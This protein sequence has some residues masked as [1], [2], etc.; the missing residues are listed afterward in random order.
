MTTTARWWHKA[1]SLVCCK[2]GTQADNTPSFQYRIPP[3]QEKQGKLAALTFTGE[4]IFISCTRF[5]NRATFLRLSLVLLCLYFAFIFGFAIIIN[6][7]IVLYDNRGETCVPSYD[8]VRGA[9][10]PNFLRSFDLSWTTLSTVGYGVISTT[11]DDA[12][13]GLRYLLALEGYNG[14]V[15]SGFCGGMFFLKISRLHSRAFATFSSCMCLE[16]G[17]D[18]VPDRDLLRVQSMHPTRFSTTAAGSH[19]RHDDGM[20]HS[21]SN[22]FP[23]LTFRLLNSQGVTGGEIVNASMKCMMISVDDSSNDGQ[24]TDTSDRVSIETEQVNSGVNTSQESNNIKKIMMQVFFSLKELRLQG[25]LH[26]VESTL[27]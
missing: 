4:R 15:F 27:E 11:A 25:H 18:V 5:L 10:R 20:V 8:Y 6:V 23:V 21:N 16:F 24:S 26:F 14:I 13:L 7:V 22:S 9:S 2:A 1:T 17:R 3:R 19:D 12:C